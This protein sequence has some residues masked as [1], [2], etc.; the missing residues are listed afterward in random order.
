MRPCTLLYFI[1]VII[2]SYFVSSDIEGSKTNVA[3]NACAAAQARCDCGWW[4]IVLMGREGGS[5]D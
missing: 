1:S 5:K 3:M 2:Y 4:G